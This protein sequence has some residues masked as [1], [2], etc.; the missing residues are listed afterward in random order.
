MLLARNWW[1]LAIRGVAAILFGLGCFLWPGL[2]LLVLITFFAVYALIE[3]IALLAALVRG[4]RAA[5]RHAWAVGIM[6]VLSLIAGIIALV[7]PGLTAITLAIFVG[8]WAIVIGIF[9]L[10]AAITLRREITGELWMGLAGVISI[11]FGLYVLVLPGDGLLSL[12]W[13]LGVWA[14]LFGLFTLMLAFRVRSHAALAA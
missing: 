6:G 3:G 7:N 11:L 5:R 14:L 1:L 4:D 13:L 8:A 10:A 2:T 9:Q 12:L